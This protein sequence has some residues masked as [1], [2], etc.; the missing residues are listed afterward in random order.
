LLVSALAGGERHAW[1][2]NLR[3]LAFGVFQVRLRLQ[4]RR[5]TPIYVGVC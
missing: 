4:G 1:R 3:A 5:V 2:E